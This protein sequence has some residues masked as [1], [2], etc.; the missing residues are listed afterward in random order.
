M[1]SSK[2]QTNPKRSMISLF[3]TASGTWHIPS[4]LMVASWLAGSLVTGGFIFA[5]LRVNRDDR[6]RAF[7]KEQ[8]SSVKIA[9]LE[10]AT[11]PKPLKDRLVAQLEAI[12]PKILI[13][14]RSGQTNFSGD[15]QA[16]HFTDLQKLASEPGASAYITFRPTGSLMITNFGQTNSAVFTLNPSLIKP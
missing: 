9:E 3:Q 8:Q 14:L 6:I 15:F 12:S 2:E 4:I 11:R 7:Q 16:H 5:N 13:G 1:S 10:L